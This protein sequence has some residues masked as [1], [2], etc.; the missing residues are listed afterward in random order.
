MPILIS[1]PPPIQPPAGPTDVVLT[2]TNPVIPASTTA[3]TNV[4]ALSA[5]GGVAPF[6]Y[7]IVNG[8]TK[9]QISGSNL[10]LSAAGQGN[11]TNGTQ[12]TIILR[13]TDVNSNQSPTHSY[14]VTISPGNP[15]AVILTPTNPVIPPSTT[16]GTNVGALSAT[17][18]QSPFTYAITNGNLKFQVSGSNLQLSAAGQ[19]NITNGTQETVV[20]Q[21]TDSLSHTSP[22]QAYQINIS[23]NAPTAVNLTPSNPSVLANALNG[24]VV[25]VAAGVGGTPPYTYTEVSGNTKFTFVGSSSNL[26][27]TAAGQGH[28]S[29]GTQEAVII[30]AKDANNLNSPTHSYLIAVP[31]GPTNVTYTNTTIADNAPV[32]TVVAIPSMVGGTPPGTFT[33]DDSN[34][35]FNF[36]GTKYTLNSTGFGHLVPGVNQN[37]SCHATDAAGVS[38]SPVPVAVSVYDH[39]T[40]KFLTN[41]TLVNDTGSSESPMWSKIFGHVF[42]QGDII[43]GTYPIFKN[44]GGTI[45]PYSMSVA[46]TYW[47]DNSLKHATFVLLMGGNV[48]IAGNSSVP[49]GI[50]NGGPSAPTPSSRTQADFAAANIQHQVTGLDNLV[51]QWTSNLN[52]GVSD[53]N[54]DNYLW[55]DGPAGKMWRIRSSYRNSGGTAE[56][57]LEAYWYV[58]SMQDSSGA[59]GHIRVQGRICLPWVDRVKA[60]KLWY[61]FNQS[62]LQTGGGTTVLRDLVLNRINVQDFTLSAVASPPNGITTQTGDFLETGQLVRLSTTGTLPAPLVTGTSYW[63]V[64]G[65]TQSPTTGKMGFAATPSLAGVGTQINLTAIGSGTAT[66]YPFICYY[67][68]SFFCGPSAEWDSIRGGGSVVT[69]VVSRVTNDQ[70]YWTSTLTI[71]SWN[72]S[73]T[74]TSNPAVVNFTTM[75]YYANTAGPV[76]VNVPGGGE[77]VDIGVFSTWYARA[78]YNQTAIDQLYVR[79]VGLVGGNHGN[80]WRNSANS[81]RLISANNGHNGGGTQYTGMGPNNPYLSSSSGTISG[82][83]FGIAIPDLTPDVDT[84]IFQNENTEHVAGYNVYPFLMTGSPEFLDLSLEMASKFFLQNY[85]A[86][87]PNG[88]ATTVFTTTQYAP[89]GLS[90]NSRGGRQ[91]LTSGTK[92]YSI[93]YCGGSQRSEAWIMRTAI[94][95]AGQSPQNHPECAGYW[96]YFNDV[97]NDNVN[98]MNDMIALEPTAFSQNA[99]L[100]YATAGIPFIDSWQQG[101]DMQTW[102]WGAGATSNSGFISLCNELNK[103]WCTVTN[104]SSPYFVGAEQF[105][106]KTG[107]DPAPLIADSNLISATLGVNAAAWTVGSADMTFTI[108]TAGSTLT[109]NVGDKIIFTPSGPGSIQ[110]PTP[111][112]I[113]RMVPY[114]I[115]SITGTA[116][117]WV[118]QLSATPNGSPIVMTDSF[119]QNFLAPKATMGTWVGQ[120]SDG[121]GTAPGTVLTVTSITSGAIGKT[122]DGVNAFNVSGSGISSTQVL[123]QTSG[124]NQGIGNYTVNKSQLT[125]VMTMTGT[126]GHSVNL[127]T[128]PAVYPPTGTASPNTANGYLAN[129]YGSILLSISRGATADPTALAAMA[130]RAPTA[131]QYVSDPKYFFSSTL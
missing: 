46:P 103:W 52:R 67:G 119:A 56:G 47:P 62:Q 79:L 1:N 128:N 105:I 89:L 35:F 86:P 115:V 68:S 11:I 130:S 24:S 129:V 107:G 70:T 88:F 61:S 131:S 25:A 15:T 84:C 110:V 2:P 4:G 99:G 122:A 96:Q 125:P 95:A 26:T 20:L 49:I 85:S 66:A 42:K 76:D 101:Y 36:D 108:V 51:G 120:I 92:R 112:A 77:R 82:T 23:A 50:Y 114:Y 57:N 90:G 28:L 45:L 7:S 31:A 18:G 3:N 34:T 5:V 43:P 27:L 30:Q 29:P 48:T 59:F 55:L 65:T 72:R 78:I 118:A 124:T 73:I 9:F 8:N 53:A 83:S 41:I 64:R 33:R 6:T 63:A 109:M 126:Y 123:A 19:G 117:T 106:V 111:L 97:V 10:Q 40:S 32:G 37:L 60:T 44:A 93:W 54:S 38:T 71:P 87:P 16:A 39:S 12:E 69:D 113:T 116:P 13:A 74:P 127:Y 22:T 102:G 81:G 91:V 100:F 17:G 104:V 21:A 80:A 58:M 98:F 94:A 121:T 14:Q 75:G